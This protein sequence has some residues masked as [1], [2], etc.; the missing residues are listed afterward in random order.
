MAGPGGAAAAGE[1]DSLAGGQ[2]TAAHP[3]GPP[4]EDGD[5]AGEAK[6]I[7]RLLTERV[8][9]SAERIAALDDDALCV[10]PAGIVDSLVHLHANR[11]G[12]DQVGERLALGLLHRALASLDAAPLPVR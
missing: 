11:I 3:A 12:L 4:G 6:P 10:P 8:R 1:R 2:G 7:L 5:W 9:P